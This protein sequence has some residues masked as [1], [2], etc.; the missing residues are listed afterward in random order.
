MLKEYSIAEVRNRLTALIRE[1]E[2]KSPIKLT[3][4]GKPVAVLISIQ[5]YER[6]AAGNRQFWEAYTT[7]RE[8]YDLGALNI[9]PTDFAGIRDRSAGREVGW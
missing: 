3:R 7:F 6:L 8:E 9:Q 1:V 2:Q 4:R 5:E